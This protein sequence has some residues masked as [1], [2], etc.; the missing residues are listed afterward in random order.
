MNGKVIGQMTLIYGQKESRTSVGKTPLLTMASSGWTSMIF[1]MS[2]MKYIFAE[3]IQ[4][5]KHGIIF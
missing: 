4:I 5:Q 1:A 3:T 2:L